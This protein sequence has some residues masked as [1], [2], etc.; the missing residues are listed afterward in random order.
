[1]TKKVV[2]VN[3]Q[4]PFQEK[5]AGSE[6]IKM[7]LA[8]LSAI[9][10]NEGH[11][12]SL[13]DFRLCDSF[14]HAVRKTVSGIPDVVCITAFSS[15]KTDAIRFGHELRKA[16]PDVIL[17]IG[18][19][20]ASLR[21]EEF[22]AERCFDYIVRGEGEITVPKIVA[23]PHRNHVSEIL[24]GETPDLD[25]LPFPDRELWPDYRER[26]N[27]P[28]V[29][30]PGKSWV[31]IISFRG[32]YA[33]CRF[34]SAHGERD[35][36]TRL[37]AEGKRVPYLRGRSV[38]NV[39]AELK[40]LD[41]KYHYEGIQFLD[42]Q[43]I[44]NPEWMWKFCYEIE[45]AGL[46]GKNWWIGTR[47]DVLLKNKELMLRMKEVTGEMMVSVGWESFSQYHLDF[48]EKGTTVQQNWE[49]AAFLREH[50]FKIFGNVIMGAPREDS[51]WYREDDIKNIEAM[52]KIKPDWMSWSIFTAAPGCDLEQ[53][54]ID[55]GL[56]SAHNVGFRNAGESKIKGVDWRWIRRQMSDR[57]F[58]H[59]WYDCGAAFLE[60]YLPIDL[61]L[62]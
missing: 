57:P 22:A 58:W 6:Y 61:H 47:V 35:H 2:L 30:V 7:G 19:I 49:A 54:C 62:R 4:T 10:K 27:C 29:Y 44:M 26:V 53:W 17:V 24:W 60:K 36:F 21:P 18:G 42:D 5:I 39:I 32:C 11:T 45:K 13:V 41:A 50:G 9:M 56:S 31:D 20:H 25:A 48:W 14:E 43:W 12:V 38:E 51:K 15:E 46:A 40:E 1:M 16:M 3:P 23:D 28:P 8:Y 37:N 59:D 52:K 33:K 55:N 34:C